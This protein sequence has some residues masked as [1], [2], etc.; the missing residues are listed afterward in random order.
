M[1][2]GQKIEL[3]VES[4]GKIT[5]D[6]KSVNGKV[7]VQIGLPSKQTLDNFKAGF[8]ESTG[9][10]EGSLKF[11]MAKPEQDAPLILQP[12]DKL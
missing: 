9:F 2:R 3:N 4:I 6:L 1:T 10:A 11:I 7:L 5:V 8:L 12:S